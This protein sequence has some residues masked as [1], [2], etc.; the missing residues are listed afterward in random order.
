MGTKD[1]TGLRK[2]TLLENSGMPT[3]IPENT[4]VS[5]APHDIMSGSSLVLDYTPLRGSE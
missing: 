4:Q 5:K 3:I 1:Q 2:K